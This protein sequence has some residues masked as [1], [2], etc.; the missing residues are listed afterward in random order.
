M[1]FDVTFFIFPSGVYHVQQTMPMVVATGDS[2]D[3]SYNHHHVIDG[4]EIHYQTAD[5]QIVD[6][7]QQQLYVIHPVSSSQSARMIIFAL[8]WKYFLL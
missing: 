7:R 8:I 1:C 5:G 6:P 4:S 3:I 2:V